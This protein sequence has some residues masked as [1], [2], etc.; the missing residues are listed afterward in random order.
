[1]STAVLL[2]TDE[3]WF[4]SNDM[5]VRHQYLHSSQKRSILPREHAQAPCKVMVWGC[6]GVGFKML[7]VIRFPEVGKRSLKSEEY[8]AQCIVP[9][10]KKLKQKRLKNRVLM[11]DGALIHWT[12]AVRTAVETLGRETV[13][14][15]EGWPAHSPDMNPLEHLWSLLQSRVSERGPWSEEELEEYVLDEF[16]KI[17]QKMV[18]DYVRSFDARCRECVAARGAHV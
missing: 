2:F 11:Q 9:L 4:D 17:P 18:D 15:L 8:V 7:V 14:L 13:T 5:G 12:P 10:G 6:I 16:G 3:K 1:M